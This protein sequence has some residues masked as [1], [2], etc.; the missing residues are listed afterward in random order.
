MRQAPFYTVELRRPYHLSK[1]LEDVIDL[2]SRVTNIPRGAQTITGLPDVFV[3]E[4]VSVY[5]K[6]DSKIGTF[7]CLTVT[8]S[9]ATV[10]CTTAKD[11]TQG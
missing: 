4:K 6:K 2:R 7:D 10:L 1:G 3:H 8:H 9:L 5:K 11:T